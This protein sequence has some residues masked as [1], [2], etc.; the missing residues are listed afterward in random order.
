MDRHGRKLPLVVML[1]LVWPLSGCARYHERPLTKLA[2]DKALRPPTLAQLMRA[3]AKIRH[4]ILKPVK[5][6]L[7]DGISPDEAGVLAVLLN[8]SLRVER[9]RRGVA[10]AQLIEAGIIPN[11]QL[12][13]GIEIPVG[14]GTSGSTIP[15]SLGLEFD[16]RAIVLRGSKVDAARFNARQVDI[17]VAWQELVIAFGARLAAYRVVARIAQLRLQQEV[18]LRLEQNLKT[19]RRAAHKGLLTDLELLASRTALGEAREELVAVQKQAALAQLKLKALIGL[20]ASYS[21][22][23]QQG[24]QLPLSLPPID[25]KALTRRLEQRRLDIVALSYGYKSQEARVR[26][27]IL[28]Q[29]PTIGIGLSHSRD[30]ANF[31]TIGFGITIELP[32]FDR[33]QGTIA[34]ERA[35]R[36]QL[37]DEYVGRLRQARAEIARLASAVGWL[38]RQIRQTQE[39]LPHL[40]QLLTT[41]KNALKLGQADILS[42]YQTWNKLTQKRIQ[43][44]ELQLSLVEASLAISLAAGYYDV[45]ARRGHR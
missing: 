16:L 26:A 30:N 43:L 19:V 7:A 5:L 6:N 45:R 25:A 40:E 14:K 1:A 2:I 12:T 4:P 36:K 3:A 18:V 22:T 15:Y 13:G 32:I 9:D 34:L 39:T 10:R 17:S 42:Y 33:N 37:F 31:S 29:F 24:T 21:L 44:V 23:M 27:A 28:G 38:N 20:P 41:Y 11:P 8:P 35:T